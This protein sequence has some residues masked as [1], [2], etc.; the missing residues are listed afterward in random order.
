VD[1]QSQIASTRIWALAGA[2]CP[3][4]V[5]V[6]D[7]GRRPAFFPHFVPTPD[8]SPLSSISPSENHRSALLPEEKNHF[9]TEIDALGVVWAVLYVRSYLEAAEFF[10][11]CDHHAIRAVLTNMSPSASINRWRLGLAEYTY[12]IQLKPGNSRNLADP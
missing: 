4:D 5:G 6:S 3:K 11:R 9:F 12:K 2:K 10:V 7:V 8:S 1:R